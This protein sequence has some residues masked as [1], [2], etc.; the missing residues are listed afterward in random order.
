MQLIQTSSS[1]TS[2]VL[3]NL[4]DSEIDVVVGSMTVSGA[5]A[6]GFS[7]AADLGYNFDPL[8]P[9]GWSNVHGTFLDHSNCW[10]EVGVMHEYANVYVY[11]SSCI[12][13]DPL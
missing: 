3:R 8:Y 1:P 13:G 4:T 10:G 2:P 12:K 7:L 9:I 6:A 5:N 11:E